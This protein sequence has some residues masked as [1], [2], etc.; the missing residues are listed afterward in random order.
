MAIAQR[1]RWHNASISTEINAALVLPSDLLVWPLVQVTVEDENRML[2]DQLA[3]FGD[4]G[5][6]AASSVPR[7]HR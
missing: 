5:R 2:R 1:M 7:G 6:E 4:A 3:R